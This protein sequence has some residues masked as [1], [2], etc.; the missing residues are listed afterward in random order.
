MKYYPQMWENTNAKNKGQ[1][2]LTAVSANRDKFKSTYKLISQNDTGKRFPIS[3]LEYSNI[4]KIHPTQKPVPLFEYLIK[5]YSNEGETVLDNC[6]GS[7]TTA[8]ASI[9]TK[10]NYI[11]IEMD[12]SYYDISVNRVNVYKQ[13]QLL[14]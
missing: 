2:I 14:F 13:Q 1:S 6:S 8:I 7:G 3:I 10:R 5:T 11:C 12:K 9:N 4:D